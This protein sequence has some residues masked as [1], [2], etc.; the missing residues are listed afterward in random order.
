MNKC[1]HCHGSGVAPDWKRLGNELSRRRVL[2]GMSLRSVARQCGMSAAHLSDMEKGRR[3]MGGPKAAIVLGLFDLHVTQAFT[4][5][6]TTFICAE[7]GIKG[8]YGK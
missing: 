6:F 2:C 8:E 1:K 4:N 7:D 5:P 3:S